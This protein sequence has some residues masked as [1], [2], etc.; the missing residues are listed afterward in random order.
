[1]CSILY[2]YCRNILCACED[3]VGIHL[4]VALQ[5]VL[6]TLPTAKKPDLSG[7]T[8]NTSPRASHHSRF[9]THAAH[10]PASASLSPQPRG[11]QSS[12]QHTLDQ[13]SKSSEDHATTSPPAKTNKR[14]VAEPEMLLPIQGAA[15]GKSVG[16]CAAEDTRNC[17]DV[18]RPRS[19]VGVRAESE[20]AAALD[21]AQRKRAFHASQPSSQGY[22]ALTQ[23]VIQATEVS[24]P[25]NS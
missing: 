4:K 21:A 5:A 23:P 14:N 8:I 16:S 25:Y 24:P 1:M 7:L 11:L 17:P 22:G 20:L 3:L 9:R 6:E 18:L 2:S 19:A 13:A 10:A 12:P 15:P